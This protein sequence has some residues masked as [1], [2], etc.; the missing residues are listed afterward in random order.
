[1]FVSDHKCTNIRQKK[2]H[3]LGNDK[4]RRETSNQGMYSSNLHCLFSES[5]CKLKCDADFN[6]YN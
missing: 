4:L 5:D 3:C 2:N 6:F 1:M